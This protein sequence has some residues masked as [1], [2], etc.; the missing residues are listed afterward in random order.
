MK[1]VDADA[2]SMIMFAIRWAPFGGAPSDELMITFG[3]SRWRFLQ[4]IR[5]TLRPRISDRGDEQ[6][7]KRNLLEV[8][9]WSWQ[10]YPDSSAS[11]PE[12]PWGTIDGC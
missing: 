4:I 9:N 11:H 8:V 1:S 10:A 12:H 2:R 5:H 7:I 3:V 6:T